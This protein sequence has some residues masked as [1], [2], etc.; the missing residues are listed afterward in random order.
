LYYQNLV[1]IKLQNDSLA[2]DT[3][4]EEL[5]YRGLRY[6]RDMNDLHEE[7]ENVRFKGIDGLSPEALYFIIVYGQD[8][9]IYQHLF[10]HIQKNDG[11][12]KT[13]ERR[14]ASR[15]GAL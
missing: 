5:A 1:R 14:P 8:E 11:T 10:R 15:F 6:V 2:R 7:T 9:N 3:Y 13:N 4:T 12:C